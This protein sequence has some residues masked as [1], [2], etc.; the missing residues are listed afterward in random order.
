MRNYIDRTMNLID[1]KQYFE[2]FL[3][4]LIPLVLISF[5]YYVLKIIIHITFGF[6][7]PAI[8]ILGV[9]YYFAT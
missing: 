2:A 5:A 7:L 4:V 3:R 9:I 8:I 6:F 1:Q